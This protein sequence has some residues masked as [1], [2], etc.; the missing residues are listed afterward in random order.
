MN[1]KKTLLSALFVGSIAATA[2]AQCL[3]PVNSLV[4]STGY[5]PISSSVVSPIAPDPMWKLIQSPTPPSPYNVTLGGPAWVIPQNGA[6]DAAGSTSQ[7]I[8][9]FNT[10]ASVLNNWVLSST[11]YIFERDFCICGTSG[12][13]SVNFD[14]NVHCDNW[15]EVQ[16]WDGGGS[17]IQNIGSQSYTYS[18]ANFRNPV[19][20]FVSTA[21]LAPGTYKLRIYM[22][23]KLVAMG[24]ALD[25]TIVSNG[26]LSDAGC[27][28][29]GTISGVKYNDCDQ[30]GTISQGD[31]LVQGIDINLI[32]SGGTTIATATTDQNGVYFFNT[33]APGTYTVSEVL[34]SGWT[35]VSPA[36]GSHTG[37]VVVAAGV[38]QL[39]FLNYNPDECGGGT[40]GGCEGFIDFS[41]NI[42]S[43]GG[44]FTALLSGI[45]SGYNV[46]FTQW[47]FGDQT[48]SNE[49]NPYHYYS[50]PGTYQVTL[51]II[52]F[53]GE[54]CCTYDVS[55]TIVIEEACEKDCSFEADII[56][57]FNEDDCSFDFV[58]Y[59][60]YAGV[61]VT[62]WFWDFGDGTTG[63]GSTISGHQFPGPG[64]YEVCVTLFGVNLDGT[65]CCFATFCTEVE[66]DCDPCER[67]ERSE[68][69]AVDEG[70]NSL[71]MYPNP[72]EGDFTLNI[73]LNEEAPVSIEII[74]M[75]GAVLYSKDLGTVSKGQHNFRI[76]AELAT[77]MY[78]ANVTA[79]DQQMRERL[80]IK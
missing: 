59:I 50:T 26:L 58:A 79:G 74:D 72:S 34:T 60:S 6:W 35:A 25:G 30:S 28:Q 53:N 12:T 22:R 54:E 61:P 68:R 16:L 8:N 18:T 66:V 27:T 56:S 43:C 37:V 69:N 32:N 10:N 78:I 33:V 36:G 44:Q 3:E 17:F 47:T 62:N 51:K 24:V 23:N 15:A 52:T 71:Q 46:V 2:G 9:A 11:P 13:Y 57:S 41:E 55:K 64:S 1:F 39:D 45:S 38:N 21:N 73:Q 76:A 49:T 40:G 70:T 75:K 31:Q 14:L 7:Y 65:D 80:V 42:E 4:V 20:N 77:G 5:N 63:N 67:R 29:S 19:D 48:S